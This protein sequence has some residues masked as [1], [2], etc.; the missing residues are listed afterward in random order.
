MLGMTRNGVYFARSDGRTTVQQH[1]LP[2][3]NAAVGDGAGLVKIQ[4]IDARE[5]LDG[6]QLLHQRV[7]AR[8]PHG[9]HR[10][11]QRGQQHQPF[12]NHAHHAGHG[13]NRRLPPFAGGER[14]LPS[15]EGL[16][17][18]P[19]KQHAQWHDDEGHELQNRVDALVQVG[20]GFLVYLGLGRQRGR[21]RV[22]P[23]GDDLD[24][25]HA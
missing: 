17:L 9:R 23:H 13:R 8:K 12:G 15:A 20:D 1:Y 5:R 16:H 24:Q 22:L 25:C 21:I 6:F 4:T 19:D 11:V 2:Q 10:K 7:L 14:R 3:G 18:R